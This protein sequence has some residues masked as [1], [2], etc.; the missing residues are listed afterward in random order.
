MGAPGLGVCGFYDIASRWSSR[1]S[2]T[3]RAYV[4]MTGT[5]PTNLKPGEGAAFMDGREQVHSW[6]RC[7]LL[8]LGIYLDGAEEVLRGVESGIG[9]VRGSTFSGSDSPDCL[10]DLCRDRRQAIWTLRAARRV[11]SLVTDW[12]GQAALTE[13]LRTAKGVLHDL[14]DVEV[15]TDRKLPVEGRLRRLI[16]RIGSQRA[17][18]RKY[19]PQRTWQQVDALARLVMLDDERFVTLSARHWALALGCSPG[20]V[21]TLPS[22]KAAMELTGRGRNGGKAKT[23]P[24]T[25]KMLA[26]I[27]LKRLIKEH[28]RNFVPSPLDDDPKSVQFV[29]RPRR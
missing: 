20:L 8:L 1:V 6:P 3:Q 19:R 18:I 5:N 21:A 17:A 7:R 25:D 16:E 13:I 12:P 23:L 27:E 4:E 14:C 11:V 28:D 22:W 9:H 10:A 24:L 15:P 2:F 26:S 29:N